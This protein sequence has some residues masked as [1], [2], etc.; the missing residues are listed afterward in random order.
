MHFVIICGSERRGGNTDRVAHHATGIIDEFGAEA[1]ILA[2]QDYVILPCGRC[3]ECNLRA[4]SCEQDD[5]MPALIA[6]LV[7]ADAL[8]YMAPVHGFGLAHPMQIF[9]E[10][11]GVGY[12]R[13]ERPLANKIGGVVITGRRY[14]HAAVHTQILNNL[15][16]NRMIV[17]GSGYPVLLHGGR[18]G[19]A[20]QDEEGLDALRHLIFRMVSLHRVLASCP[21][22]IRHKHLAPLTPNER[23]SAL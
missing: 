20:L 13:F 23:V 5:D 16:L 18:P 8:L 1:E 22:T 10:R 4:T 15:L 14:S 7:A 12:L 17:I 11:A 3:G 9:I 21:D 19:A 6:R 2:L